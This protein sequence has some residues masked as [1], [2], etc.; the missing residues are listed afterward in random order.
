MPES[1]LDFRS[2]NLQQPLFQLLLVPNLFFGGLSQARLSTQRPI[3]APE[4]LLVTHT[5]GAGIR[6]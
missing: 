4:P 1:V 3:C 2:E 6:A 5:A